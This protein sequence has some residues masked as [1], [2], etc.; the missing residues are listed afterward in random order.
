MRIGLLGAI[1]YA[2]AFLAM[3]LNGWHS[4]RVLE[5]HWHSAIPLLCTA[6]GLL[7]L[8]LLPGS[9]AMTV[10]W[11]SLTCLFMAFLPTFWA[12]PTEILS[13]STAALAVG[14]INAFASVAGFAGPYVF[15]Y[16]NTRTGSFSAGFVVLMGAAVMSAILIVL[17][18]KSCLPSE[19]K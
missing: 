15:G 10:G 14:L 12:I 6:A 18:P 8:L 3:L 16:L 13:E 17:T 2:V 5:R 1:P 19:T 7:G 9:T 11:F 4:D